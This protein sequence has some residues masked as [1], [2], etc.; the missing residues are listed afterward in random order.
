M[1]AIHERKQA[2]L[3]GVSNFSLDQLQLLCSEASIRPRFVQNRCFARDGWDRRVRQF[4]AAHGIIYQGFSL[5]TANRDV[6]NHPELARIA[7]RHGRTVSQVVFRFAIDVGMIA[8]TGTTSARHMRGD[9]D[10]FQFKLDEGEVGRI[11]GVM[12]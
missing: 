6:L 9:L 10:V 3:I 8:L 5:L 2:R 4:C 7:Q 12:G 11:E 1:E